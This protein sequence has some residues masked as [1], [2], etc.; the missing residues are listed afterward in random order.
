ME[1]R[2]RFLGWFN[3]IVG[4]LT[5]AFVL[6]I[7]YAIAAANGSLLPKTPE[8]WQSAVL[9][10]AFFVYGFA[11]IVTGFGL[12]KH[13]IWAKQLASALSALGLFMVPIGTAVGAYSLWVLFHPE[14]KT[15]FQ[16][17]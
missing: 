14:T 4:I 11:G 7:M 1:K 5:D 13:K 17:S 2:V 6:F 12:F 3:M 10:L 9:V 15:F 8:E 16:A